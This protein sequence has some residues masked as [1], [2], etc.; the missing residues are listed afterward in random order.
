VVIERLSF[1]ISPPDRVE[2]FI[3]ADEVVWGPWLRNQ[4]GF[5]RKTI[6]R[7]PGGRVDLRLFW[8]SQRDLDK[9]AKD[10]QIPAIDVKLQSSFLGVFTR[11]P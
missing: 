2:D 3:E 10:P 7:Y 6:Q 8:A 4:R 11:L 1:L 9:A 5:L